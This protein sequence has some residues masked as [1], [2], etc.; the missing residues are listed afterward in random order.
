[1]ACAYGQ[2]KD[3]QKAYDRREF[4]VKKLERAL[5]DF[6]NSPEK[7]RP[8]HKTGFLG[9]TGKKVDSIDFYTQKLDKYN[10]RHV[11]GGVRLCKPARQ[12]LFFQP[13]EKAA[14]S[15]DL[16]HLRLRSLQGR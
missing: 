16:I 7:T 14:D 13:L 11:A 12:A 15:I 2:C 8:Q 4:Y 1:M 5:W 10:T 9:L 3:L 6:N